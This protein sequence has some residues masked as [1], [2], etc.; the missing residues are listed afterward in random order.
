MKF[1]TILFL[2][3]FA[4]KAAEPFKLSLP[5]DNLALFE[6]NPEDFY[7]FNYRTLE[8]KT[9]EAWTG[10]QYGFVRNLITTDKE[11]I[12]ATRFHE[13]LDIKPTKRDNQGNPLD[14]IRA[15]ANG[16][17]VHINKNSGGSTYGKYIVIKHDWGYGPFYSLYA[18]LSQANVEL[19]QRVLRDFP[20][21][22]MG[23]T[24]VGLNRTRAHLHL[25]LCM[26]STE[27]FADWLGAEPPH[28][29]FDGRNL[30]GLDLASLYQAVKASNDIT[31]PNFLKSASPYF[32]VAIP[33]KKELEITK[34]YPWLKKGD[35]DI[36]SPSLEISFTDSGIPLSIVPSHRQVTKATLTY[37][38]TTRSRHEHYTR[39]RLTGSGR[40]ASLTKSG[41]KFIALF[42][43][44]Y[45]KSKTQAK[46]T[47]DS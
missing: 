25:E 4:L 44:E 29:N 3:P 30:I 21:G 12:I 5:T 39:G 43:N 32:K 1:F 19:G 7:M 42:T 22:V 13:G 27:N 41:E 8:G 46:G 28:R 17:V 24:G 40:K 36:Q 6:G 15:I 31:I 9:T 35:H 14:E 18:H 20:I 38:R 10:G 47:D 26:L 37:V 16:E 23:F 11:G 45:T 34:R 33:R 2:F